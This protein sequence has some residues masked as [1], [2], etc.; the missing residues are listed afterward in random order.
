M[1]LI[2]LAA[3]NI[4]AVGVFVYIVVFVLSEQQLRPDAVFSL[5]FNI[6]FSFA[7]VPIV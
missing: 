7:A 2:F 4:F 6:G 3:K 5:E 1:L